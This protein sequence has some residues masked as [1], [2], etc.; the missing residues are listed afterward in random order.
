MTAKVWDVRTTK[1]VQTFD[2][3]K[4]EVDAV[5]FFP[6]GNA[7][8]TGYDDGTCKLFD[9]RADTE[10]LAYSHESI[11]TAVTSIDFSVSGRLIFA[12][13]DDYKCHVWDTLKGERVG[14]LSAH[15]NRV[16]CLG[17]SGDGVALC[18]GSWDASLKVILEIVFRCSHFHNRLTFSIVQGVGLN[19]S[20]SFKA[21]L[22]NSLISF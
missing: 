11:S 3:H 7:F 15:E 18:T 16:S 1:C 14:I 4:S 10:M 21:T 17:V 2:T 6:N 8:V 9:L 13:Y 5:Q 19:S 20:I 22:Y 12:G